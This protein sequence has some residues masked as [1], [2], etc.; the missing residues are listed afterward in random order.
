MEED[1][2]KAEVEEDLFKAEVAPGTPDVGIKLISVV[3][4]DVIVIICTSPPSH[5]SQ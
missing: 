5:R 4:F 2:F 1:L 3:Y